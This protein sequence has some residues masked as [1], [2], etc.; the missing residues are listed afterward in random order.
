MSKRGK[1][2]EKR[3]QIIGCVI[4]LIISVVLFFLL[5]LNIE[6]NLISLLVILSISCLVGFVIGFIF[7]CFAETKKKDIDCKEADIQMLQY[8]SS[9]YSEIC[10]N[11]VDKDDK[12]Q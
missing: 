2:A 5:Y 11:N 8:I 4:S 10:T 12:S 6:K 7:F 9:V 3:I 1:R